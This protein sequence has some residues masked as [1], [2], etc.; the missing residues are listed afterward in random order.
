MLR[1]KRRTHAAARRAHI[2]R[3]RQPA[4]GGAEDAGAAVE[5]EVYLSEED[6]E[7]ESAPS[8]PQPGRVAVAT[9]AEPVDGPAQLMA[10]I[11][12]AGPA[13]SV[14]MPLDTDP[15]ML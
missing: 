4:R 12:S 5:E 2:L 6:I 14:L 9:A 13:A 11:Y 3:Q 15:A 10:P 8:P 7:D 1:V